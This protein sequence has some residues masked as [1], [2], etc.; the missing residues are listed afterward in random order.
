MRLGT[1]IGLFRGLLDNT[2]GSTLQTIVYDYYNT[3]CTDRG[4]IRSFLYCNL[5]MN[6]LLN[7]IDSYSIY[8]EYNSNTIA[9]GGSTEDVQNIVDIIEYLFVDFIPQLH[10]YIII[11]T[12]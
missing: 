3:V 9:D 11:Q 5:I 12:L 8:S 1:K 2:N 4:Y 10:L 6:F 7:Y